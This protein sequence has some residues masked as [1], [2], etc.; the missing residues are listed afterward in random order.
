MSKKMRVVAASL[1]AVAFSLF[2]V[3][4]ALA[5]AP[6]FAVTL[7]KTADP[8]TLPSAGG[9]VTYWFKVTNTGSGGGADL[10]AVNLSDNKCD[11]IEFEDSSDGTDPDSPGDK[12]EVGEWWL[13]SC[14]DSL[15]ATTT[16]TATVN[17]CHDGS[18]DEC[19]NDSHSATATD[20]A[21]VTVGTS[22]FT[23]DDVAKSAGPLMLALILLA[24][25]GL[26]FLG[27]TNRLPKLP[28]I[29]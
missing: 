19:N 8:A 13:F 29:S 15:T 14:E 3:G 5:Q 17:A 1:G 4:G 20:S 25:G 21:T 10:Q 16:N 27:S 18:K 28:K 24:I 23:V 9:D 26:G 7:E 11:P 22:T 12:L 6:V 2:F